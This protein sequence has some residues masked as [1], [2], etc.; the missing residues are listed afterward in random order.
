MYWSMCYINE[1]MMELIVK[2][3]II[4]VREVSLQ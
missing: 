1:L 4:V 3:L 2:E